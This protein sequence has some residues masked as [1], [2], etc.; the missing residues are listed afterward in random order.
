MMSKLLV[1]A[2][3][4]ASLGLA[5]CVMVP[6]GVHWMVP[7]QA[8]SAASAP[9]TA[10]TLP[11]PESTVPAGPTKLLRY[12]DISKDAV[13]FSYAGDLWIVFAPGRRGPPPHLRSR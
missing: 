2:A 12:A 3:V 11:A 10:A 9:S 7:G 6:L 5:V 8:V 1:R 4:C 13:V